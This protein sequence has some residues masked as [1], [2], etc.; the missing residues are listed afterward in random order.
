MAEERIV[1]DVLGYKWLIRKSSFW[2]GQY[3][4]GI[5]WDVNHELATLKYLASVACKA[6]VFV[7]V[8]A[9]V[10]YYS[11]R[12]AKHYDHV[13]AIEPD[14]YNVEGLK[15]NLELN[16]IINVYVKSLACGSVKG[17]QTLFQKFVG[18]S[19]Y[20]SRSRLSEITVDVDLLD[21]LVPNA[22]A[23]KIDTEGYEADVLEGAKRLIA[24]RALFVVEDH[25]S[26]YGD[27]L[28]PD[29][30]NRILFLLKDYKIVKLEG[31][32]YLFKPIL[33]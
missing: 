30:W 17:R 29:Y 20:R 3:L 4:D 14:P 10:G 33:R 1:T 7:D 23:V 22:L 13:V 18:S 26:V 16:S 24:E 2:H 8:G 9:H 6:C 15:R 12:L 11:V 32:I 25:R 21:N 19:L 31:N 28:R 5:A 27:A